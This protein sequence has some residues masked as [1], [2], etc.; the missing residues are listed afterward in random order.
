MF[1]LKVIEP[2]KCVF[3][4]SLGFNDVRTLC[5]T[6]FE[7]NCILHKDVVVAL[8]FLLLT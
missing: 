7:Q 8:T 1:L 5:S 2:W 4:I 6:Y 3:L